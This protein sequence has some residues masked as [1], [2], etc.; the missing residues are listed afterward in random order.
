MRYLEERMRL[1][2]DGLVSDP[3][4]ECHSKGKPREGRKKSDG[5][6]GLMELIQSR[7]E[8]CLGQEQRT[9]SIKMPSENQYLQYLDIFSSVW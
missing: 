4:L 9:V 5:A 2:Y 1:R 3:C 6:A 7:S 8:P